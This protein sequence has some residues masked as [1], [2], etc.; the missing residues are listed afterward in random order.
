MSRC[1]RCPAAR[2]T[3]RVLLQKTATA[4]VLVRAVRV[5]QG[6]GVL[7]GD[8]GLTVRGVHVHHALYG[9]VLIALQ[10]ALDGCVHR[11]LRANVLCTG[12]ALVVDELDVLTGSAGHPAAPR[13]RAVQDALAL[14]WAVRASA[15]LRRTWTGWQ[16]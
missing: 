16:G 14:L 10:Q 8:G 2:Q 1:G 6:R 3:V 12:V 11:P 4:Y 5:L 9:G 13:V 7:P 15:D